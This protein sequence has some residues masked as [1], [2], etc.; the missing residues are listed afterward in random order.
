[1]FTECQFRVMVMASEHLQ[2]FGLYLTGMKNG[3]YIV[4]ELF[5]SGRDLAKLDAIANRFNRQLHY[6]GKLYD[7][8][9]KMRT[10]K[11]CFADPQYDY[12]TDINGT[13]KSVCDY[14]RNARLNVGAFPSENMQTPIAI[15][16]VEIGL[17]VQL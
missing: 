6:V 7:P 3:V 10:I 11:V 9:I 17:K 12:S 16:F 5:E 4:P 8:H 14:F 1:M 2:K 13:R 15:E